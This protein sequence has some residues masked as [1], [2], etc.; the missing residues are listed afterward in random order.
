LSVTPAAVV[1][2]TGAVVTGVVVLLLP[3]P[4][5][6]ADAPAA[7]IPARKVRLEGAA[8]SNSFSLSTMKAFP[9]KE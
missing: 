9:G 8:L 6:T 2:V 4:T 5:T 1:V 3:Q 7:P